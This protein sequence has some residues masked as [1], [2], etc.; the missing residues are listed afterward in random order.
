MFARGGERL[1]GWAADFVNVARTKGAHT[2]MQS[3]MLAAESA[4]EAISSISAEAS[5][6]QPVSLDAT[7][8]DTALWCS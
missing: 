6:E 2:V 4:F 5:E 8:Y 1:V 7:S 3:G